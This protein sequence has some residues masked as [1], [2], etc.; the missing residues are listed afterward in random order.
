MASFPFMHVFWVILYCYQSEKFISV[1]CQN[2]SIKILWKKKIIPPKF[3]LEKKCA[4][5]LE[6][7]LAWRCSNIC[8]FLMIIC[9]T[10]LDFYIPP[11]PNKNFTLQ[12][13][14]VSEQ[15]SASHFSFIYPPSCSKRNVINFIVTAWC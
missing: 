15:R 10:L 2:N 12:C 1:C 9:H 3:C 6:H 5:R 7:P 8:I 4:S 11:A 13:Y 14:F